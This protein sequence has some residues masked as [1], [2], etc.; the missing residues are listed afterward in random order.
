MPNAKGVFIAFEG[1][2]AAGKST[3]AALLATRLEA[4]LTR[5]PGGT[6]LGE[7]IRAILLDPAQV[8]MSDRAEA[9]LFAAARAQLV[10]EVIKPALALGRHVVTDRFAGS[11]FAYQA[12]G[13]GLELAQVQALSAFAVDE[14]WPDL[15]VLI[16]VPPEVSQSR[17]GQPDRLEAAGTQFHERVAEGFA[18]LASAEPERWLRVSGLGSPQDVAARVWQG[19]SERLSL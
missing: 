9:L 3:Q 16:E 1:G 19:V 18:Q 8:Q 5:E 17:M 11:S 10:S 6:G 15:N 7:S 4:V 14:I 2:E 13:R 12:F